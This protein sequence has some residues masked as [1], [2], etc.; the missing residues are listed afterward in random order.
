MS[1]AWMAVVA[2]SATGWA[3]G[4][5]IENATIHTL[6]PKGSLN[7]ASI[8]IEGKKIR[9][10]G[11]KLDVPANVTR[12][13]GKGGVVTP[14]L[15][16]AYSFLGT[17]E[18]PSIGVTNDTDSANKDVT[19]SLDVALAYNRESTLVPIN[20]V[21]GLTRVLTAP[22]SNEGLFSGSA[23]VVQ[24]GDAGSPI[25]ASKAAMLL[26][27][28]ER[29]SD[30]A[31]GSRAAAIVKVRQALADARDYFAH[32]GD[33]Q[34][35]RRRKYELSTA[36]L[37]AL[38]PAILGK[39]PVLVRA[40]RAA[41][42]DATLRLVRDF[43][44][45]RWILLGASEGWMRAKEIAAAKV[46]VVMFPLVNNPYK[47]EQLGSSLENAA[48]LYRAGVILAFTRDDEP[49][50]DRAL[51]FA[52]GNAVAYGLPWIEGLRGLTANPAKIYGS[53]DAGTLE[54]G[55]TAD[56]VLW[57][58]DPLDV[59]SMAQ[60]VWIAGM[61]QPTVTRQTLLRDRYRIV[62]VAR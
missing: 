53:Q 60:K 17:M 56:V 30:L 21:E 15:F 29:A 49:H 13:D 8:W 6:G 39:I 54:P 28:G 24:L 59:T 3:Q 34:Q 43:P 38:V 55:K 11:E 9:A 1:R 22:R 26:E 41:D 33:Y 57:S 25:V 14:G 35:G 10:V 7:N 46:P 52:V 45:I 37:E 51:R 32:T 12:I 20:R 18:I 4:V 58:G 61:E 40:E 5:V 19:A 16:D 42:I 23:S 48:R 47:F 27:L 44:A 2:L 36:D 50:N 62:P 31:G